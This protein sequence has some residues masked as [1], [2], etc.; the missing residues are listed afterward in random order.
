MDAVPYVRLP[1]VSPRWLSAIAPARISAAPSVPFPMSTVIG[2]D[3][4]TFDPS[5]DDTTGEI[6]W[7]FKVVI[8]PEGRKSCAVEIP[9]EISPNAQ[10]RKSRIS[11]CAP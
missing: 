8:V 3:H 11:L 9:S 4:A 1:I 10:S 2:C 7:P 5:E 6:V